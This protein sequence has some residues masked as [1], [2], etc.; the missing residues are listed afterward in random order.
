M[1]DRE[2]LEDIAS[3]LA[4]IEHDLGAIPEIKAMR[5]L[6]ESYRAF[7]AQE[8]EAKRRGGRTSPLGG[9]L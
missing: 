8:Q 5:E 4:K 2:L 9:I 7:A 3:R 6:A 1:T